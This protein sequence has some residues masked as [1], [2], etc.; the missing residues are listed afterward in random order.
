MKKEDLN[1]DDFVT[2]KKES[3]E[4]LYTEK[5]LYRITYI[6]PDNRE[7]S[8]HLVNNIGT[9]RQVAP[10]SL[11]LLDKLKSLDEIINELNTQRQLE[12][13]YEDKDIQETLGLKYDQDKIRWDLLPFDSL[14]EVA[15]VLTFGAKKYKPNSWQGVEEERYKA[16][17][18]RHYSA[19][20]QGEELDSDSNL[21]HIVHL[22]C[23]ALF[24][25][26]KYLEK[27][28]EKNLY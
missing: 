27:K 13:V 3:F 2:V 25:I 6:E 16:A 18:G 10:K 11:I 7:Y 22:A 14:D 9:M 12:E 15:K 20:M 5:D 21:P 4:G 24:L 23:N 1:K 8:V 19:Y 17:L 26:H 28:N